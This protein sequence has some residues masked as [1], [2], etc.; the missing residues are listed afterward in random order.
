MEQLKIAL[1]KQ[2]RKAK[3]TSVWSPRISAKATKAQRLSITQ[4]EKAEGFDM[5]GSGWSHYAR[6][7]AHTSCCHGNTKQTVCAREAT[8]PRQ[9]EREKPIVRQ[10]APKS[11][12]W[13]LWRRGMWKSLQINRSIPPVSHEALML[14]QHRGQGVS[15]VTSQSAQ[16]GFYSPNIPAGEQHGPSTMGWPDVESKLKTPTAELWKTFA[17]QAPLTVET[18]AISLHFSGDHRAKLKTVAG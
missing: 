15:T 4:P 1:I 18:F 7:S 10:K 12:K 17:G 16:K 3:L 2:G 8:P 11:W 5:S 9:K 13:E 6:H 14:L